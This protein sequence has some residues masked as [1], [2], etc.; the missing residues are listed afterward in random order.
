M[1][2]A[3]SL[4]CPCMNASSTNPLAIHKGR[5]GMQRLPGERSWTVSRVCEAGIMTDHKGER[6]Q[7]HQS[8]S[9][10]GT[11][12]NRKKIPGEHNLLVTERHTSV[13]GNTCNEIQPSQNMKRTTHFA[14]GPVHQQHP[15]LPNPIVGSLASSFASTWRTMSVV[16]PRASP[17]AVVKRCGKS[18]PIIIGSRY[19][20]CI[21]QR[22]HDHRLTERL[23]AALLKKYIVAGQNKRDDCFLLFHDD[24]RQSPSRSMRRSR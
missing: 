23:P 10:L 20:P 1:R 2:V 22:P 3:T 17:V 24:T 19:A 6:K 13:T 14:D 8:S 7:N 21:A 11:G 18:F 16:D 5:P 4:E 12:G 15:R 9:A